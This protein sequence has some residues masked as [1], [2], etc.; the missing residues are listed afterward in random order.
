ML[1][2]STLYAGRWLALER[3]W[4]DELFFPLLLSSLAAR[5][6][7]QGCH[8]QSTWWTS[9][10]QQVVRVSWVVICNIAVLTLERL[11]ES[12]ER[13][14]ETQKAR[15]A[16]RISD[17][18]PWGWGLNKG[19]KKKPIELPHSWDHRLSQAKSINGTRSQAADPMQASSLV[20][21]VTMGSLSLSPSFIPFCDNTM[22]KDSIQW[23]ER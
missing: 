6:L 11:S 4:S 13:L 22:R 20:T 18:S 10:G 17:L 16:P 3:R 2:W 15:P 12:T 21:M 7:F 1:V 8:H 23:A 19:R 5:V 14:V 9:D